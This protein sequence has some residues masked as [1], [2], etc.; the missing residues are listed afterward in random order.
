M[1]LT[2]W[3]KGLD[4]GATTSNLGLTM[5]VI[6]VMEEVDGTLMSHIPYGWKGIAN[7]TLRRR[8]R[9]GGREKSKYALGREEGE[10]EKEE[11]QGE[12]KLKEEKYR[13]NREFRM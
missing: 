7:E 11:E 2:K 13:H 8:E 6:L 10:T 12:S 9:V 5:R 1:I 4:D 3:E